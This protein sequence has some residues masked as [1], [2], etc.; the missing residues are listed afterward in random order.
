[1]GFAVAV[2][3]AVQEIRPLVKFILSRRGGEGAVR[4]FCD[5]IWEAKTRDRNYG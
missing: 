2:A 5:I 1:M 3:D 4:E